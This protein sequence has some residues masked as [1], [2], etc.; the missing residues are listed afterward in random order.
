MNNAN[1]Q[2]ASAMTK[3]PAAIVFLAPCASLLRFPIHTPFFVFSLLSQASPPLAKE[4]GAQMTDI[5]VSLQK[6]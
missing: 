6:P 2:G 3:F 4:L 5:Q 1:F